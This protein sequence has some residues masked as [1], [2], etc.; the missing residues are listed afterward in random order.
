[1]AEVWARD[2]D[3]NGPPKASRARH[4]RDVGRLFTSTEVRSADR[5]MHVRQKGKKKGIYPEQYKPYA[6]GIMWNVRTKFILH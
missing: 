2:K 5:Y 1:M 6:V 3:D 4:I